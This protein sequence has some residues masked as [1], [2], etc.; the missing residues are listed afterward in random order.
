MKVSKPLRRLL[1]I[2]L[3]M[4]VVLS[5]IAVLMG[6]AAN[7]GLPAMSSSFGLL[8]FLGGLG[9][10]VV[11]YCSGGF[12]ST[13]LAPIQN[14]SQSL[15]YTL[16]N[17]AELVLPSDSPEV[18]ADLRGKMENQTGTMVLGVLSFLGFF[19]LALLFV[20]VPLLGYLALAAVLIA[21]GSFLALQHLATAGR[22]RR[23]RSRAR[24][25]SC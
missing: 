1:W 12:V 3:L 16:P 22:L 23:G 7:G 17:E 19:A 11:A 6:A 10:L 5:G 8:F 2:Y 20:Y 15:L 14:P 9:W 25:P 18:M 13:Y 21:L 24:P 4:L